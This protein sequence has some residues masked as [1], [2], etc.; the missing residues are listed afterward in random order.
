[1]TDN[2]N[3]EAVY[4]KCWTMIGELLADHSPVAVAGVMVAQAMII[5]KTML[6][7]DEYD[8][9]CTAISNARDKVKKIELPVIQ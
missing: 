7:E 4:E 9:M 5:Y 2:T 1:M 8:A 3:I 6:S